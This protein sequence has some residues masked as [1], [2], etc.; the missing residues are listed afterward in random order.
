MF[1]L[2]QSIM[3][4]SRGWV[5]AGV[6]A[7]L[8]IGA[9][10]AHSAITLTGD[11]ELPATPDVFTVD[12][13]SATTQHNRGIVDDRR[14]R[15]TFQN[16]TTMNVEE[17]YLSFD[18]TGG[19][20]GLALKFYEVDDVLA[21]D[22]LPGNLI[23][24]LTISGDL[25]GNSNWL[26]FALTGSDIFELPARST[27]TTGY[28]IEVSNAAYTS[29]NPGVLWFADDDTDYYTTGRY[30]TENGASNSTRDVGLALVGSTGPAPDP[31]DVDNDGDVDLDDLQIILDNFRH[32][33]GS[34]DLGD[35][36]GDSYVDLYDFREWKSYYP[37]ALPGGLAGLMAVPEP[38][39]W[40][41]VLIGMAGG[42]A[43]ARRRRTPAA[44]LPRSARNT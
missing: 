10:V 20:G 6:C 26:E 22:W 11:P 42:L 14:L 31:G 23:K 29:D 19:L 7:I 25:P 12:P 38:A 4:S 41:L 13:W 34:R 33:V 1:A 5:A 27:G 35:L 40:S 37:G 9:S 36:T 3:T 21:S 2:R 8:L 28:G 44:S 18:V 32:A 24:T 15:Q 17:I 16:P 43:V 30:Y 39:T